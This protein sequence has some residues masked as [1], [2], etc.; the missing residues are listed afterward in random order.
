MYQV[1]ILYNEQNGRSYYR[2][3]FKTDDI[4]LGNISTNVLPPT[5]DVI[6]AQSYWWDF[7][8]EIWNYDDEMYQRLTAEDEQKKAEEEQR[9]REAEAQLTNEEIVAALMELAENQ[10]ILFDAISEIAEWISHIRY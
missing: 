3:Y 8:A 9:R 4:A 6:E 7:E 10:S 2:S 5:Q 1:I